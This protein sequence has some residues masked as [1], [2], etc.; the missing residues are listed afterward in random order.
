LW[1]NGNFSHPVMIHYFYSVGIN[2][3]TGFKP[4]IIY[5]IGNMAIL[6]FFSNQ[7]SLLSLAPIGGPWNQTGGK[8]TMVFKT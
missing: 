6:S 5:G 8:Q 1:C 2:H 4:I 3:F 7:F